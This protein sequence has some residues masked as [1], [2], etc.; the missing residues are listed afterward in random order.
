M[1][2]GGEYL[3]DEVKATEG[4]IGVTMSLMTS[5]RVREDKWLLQA[6]SQ[7]WRHGKLC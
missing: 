7:G 3:K 5:N 6:E 2:D 1:S 4:F